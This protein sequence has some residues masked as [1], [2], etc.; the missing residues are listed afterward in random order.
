MEVVFGDWS[1]DGSGVC[2]SG[3][4]F[5]EWVWG[6]SGGAGSGLCWS[7]VVGFGLDCWFCG[8]SSW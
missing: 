7:G 2:W 6:L 5:L 1:V 3:F 8:R 4:G